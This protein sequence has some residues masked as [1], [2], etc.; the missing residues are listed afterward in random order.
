MD[1]ADNGFAPHYIIA[2]STSSG[3]S[4]FI[5]FLILQLLRSHSPDDL[6]LFLVDPK[7]VTFNIFKDLPHLYAPVVSDAKKF[8]IVL[9][10]IIEEVE[11]R[12]R[13]FAENGVDNIRTLKQ[14]NPE[15]AK[16]MPYIIVIV[17]EFADIVDS[18]RWDV[19]E[20]I[21]M[22][23]KRLGQKA[24]AAGIHMMLITQRATSTNIDGEIK[25]NMPGRIAFRV[26][27]DGDS[28]IIIDDN[29]AAGV[30]NP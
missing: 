6:R 2:G 15:V 7:V 1:P 24:R 17:D 16:Q 10:G 27:S 4:N 12:Y 13:L 28:Q 8:S 26:A 9:N 19:K 5:R 25:A 29:V 20:S 23:L 11:N 14:K 30:E 22:A 18:Q 3:K 21:V